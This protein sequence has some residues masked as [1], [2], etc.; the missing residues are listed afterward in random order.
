MPEPGSASASS[1][2][3]GHAIARVVFQSSSEVH[4]AGFRF[5]GSCGRGK[6]LRLDEFSD[7]S[8]SRIERSGSTCPKYSHGAERHAPRAD[9]RTSANG[10]RCSRQEYGLQT[11]RRNTPLPSSLAMKA[12][13]LPALCHL[14]TLLP[15]ESL[16][17][18]PAFCVWSSGKAFNFGLRD[19]RLKSDRLT[20]LV[21]H[22]PG[23]GR[24]CPS[25]ELGLLIIFLRVGA[26]NE[27]RPLLLLSLSLY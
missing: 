21:Y 26:Y 22:R 24:R 5:S 15:A 14:I 16:V 18:F 8:R 4:L 17:P 23:S 10:D 1:F 6:G 3:S 11:A 12:M 2:Q 27:G 25:H 7:S 13:C 20:V 19:T 9:L